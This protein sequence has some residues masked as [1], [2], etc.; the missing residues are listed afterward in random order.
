M[1]YPWSLDILLTFYSQFQVWHL[2]GTRRN[3]PVRRTKVCVRS[4]V[5]ERGIQVALVSL[6]PEVVRRVTITGLKSTRRSTVLDKVRYDIIPG[7]SIAWTPLHI[8]Y[9]FSLFWGHSVT[10]SCSWISV[11]KIWSRSLILL[12][13]PQDN[14][15]F[16]ISGINLCHLGA[17]FSILRCRKRFR[18]SITTF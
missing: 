5:L 17:E 3:C 6:W 18:G 8:L 1:E 12:I 13:F 14:R 9:F 15:T 16:G 2:V 11:A 10:A 7:L 4:P